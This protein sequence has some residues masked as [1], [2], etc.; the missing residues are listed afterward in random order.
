MGYIV[1]A[2]IL[3][4]LA[5]V[6]LLR[7]VTARGR[8][9][10]VKDVTGYEMRGKERPH[11]GAKQ[12]LALG[13]GS[14]GVLLVWTLVCSVTTVSPRS[15]AVETAFGKYAGTLP[16]GVHLIAPWAD[17]EELSTS[18]QTIDLPTDLANS[19]T[20]DVNFTGG[21]HGTISAQV[22]WHIATEQKARDLWAKYR[23]FDR[24]KEQLVTS[25]AADSFRVVLG[26]YTPV[27]ARAGENL[28]PIT[29]AVQHDLNHNLAY[30]GVAIDSIAVRSIALDGPTQQSIEATVTATQDI[31]RAKAEQQRAEIDARTAQ[32]RERTGAL[33]PAANQRYCLDLVNK[34]DVNK[35][36][37][38]PATFNCA[39]GGSSGST[40]VIVGNDK[41]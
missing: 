26:N 31:E 14:L 17:T 18:I 10:P 41:G 27:N 1:I 4:A 19:K 5:L 20:L 24:V 7:W 8:T 12:G 33:S 35:N 2:L 3:A 32:L 29:Q 36:G 40:P 37:P 11:P 34:W 15:V 30:D 22:R 13:L 6:G 21:G 23:T 9:V 39:L 38:L 16:P 25:D 28:R